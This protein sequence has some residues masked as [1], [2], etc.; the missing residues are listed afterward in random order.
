MGRFYI[1]DQHFFHESLNSRMDKRG[2]SSVEEMNE[3]M[4]ARWNSRIRKNDEVV[5]LGDFS[6]AKA[7][8]TEEILKRLKGKKML[9]EGNHDRFLRDKN[10]DR[11]LFEWIK[12]Y[13]S[14][15]DNNRKVILSHYP[16]FCYDGQ[17]HMSDKNKPH[18]Y[19]LYGHVHDTY[20]EKL[21]MRF[22][23]E[24]RLET[25]EVYGYDGPMS[26]PCNMINTF[27]VFSDYLPLTLD[28]W[29]KV[30]AERE[31]RADIHSTK[32]CEQ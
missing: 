27:C 31:Q 24:T 23:K 14:V 29:I 18:T 2:F 4:I 20:D 3:Y 22:Q 30:Q 25:R 16:V 28:E 8:E 13:A 26:I 12:P 11:D 6:V 17:Y 9:I 21:V 10:F 15:H 32:G 19:M 5:I 7:P 1:S